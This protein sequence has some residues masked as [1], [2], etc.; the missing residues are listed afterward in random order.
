MKQRLMRLARRTRDAAAQGPRGSLRAR[1]HE[2]EREL[3]EVRK[4]S[5]RVAEMLD[6][7]EA[8]LTPRDTE[9]TADAPSA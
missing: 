3:D 1:V 4:D 5:R 6:L 7:I 8:R 9:P 2:L